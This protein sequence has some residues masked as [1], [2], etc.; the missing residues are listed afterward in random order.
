MDKPRLIALPEITGKQGNYSVIEEPTLPFSV[1]RVYWIYNSIAGISGGNHAHLTA[2]RILVC[3]K[4][5]AR[6][7]LEASDGVRY[8]F[9]LDNPA[10]GLYFPKLHWITYTLHEDAMVLVNRLY[11]DDVKIADYANFKDRKPKT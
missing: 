6:I 11:A 7:H 1:K 2:D 9:V 4:G 3:M 5:K 8:D 10:K